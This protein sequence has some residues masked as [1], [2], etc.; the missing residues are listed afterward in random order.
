MNPALF[1]TII[2][3]TALI[4]AIC[5]LGCFA[6]TEGITNYSFKLALIV[7]FIF[8]VFVF[9]LD[10]YLA[11]GKRLRVMSTITSLFPLLALIGLA[12]YFMYFF[13]AF[14]SRIVSEK[15]DYLFYVYANAQIMLLSV[16]TWAIIAFTETKQNFVNFSTGE[17]WL[18][19]SLLFLLIAILM[20][21]LNDSINTTLTLY[22]ADG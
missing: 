8:L 19:S 16:A 7:T 22:K 3:T 13:I 1:S 4:F 6:G 12:V 17:V 9:L 18:P 15:V 2:N 21:I 11:Y 10:Y 20:Y 5:W 14:S